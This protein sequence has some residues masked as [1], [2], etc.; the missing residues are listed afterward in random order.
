MQNQHN[1]CNNKTQFNHWNL[2]IWN[3]WYVP[4]NAWI[5][6][7]THLCMKIKGDT[8]AGWDDYKYLQQIKTDLNSETNT[9]WHLF[10]WTLMSMKSQFIKCDKAVLFVILY[11]L[12][13]VS[14]D[15]IKHP[16]LFSYL[17][18][19]LYSSLHSKVTYCKINSCL[20]YMNCTRQSNVKL[21]KIL[22]CSSY[23]EQYKPYIWFY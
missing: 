12:H 15:I 22:I 14:W 11:W 3:R 17:T 5:D 2:S 16:V 1:S 10:T 7:V 9:R 23:L 18:Q 20:L 13:I 21:D 6:D 8:Y 19:S 4:E